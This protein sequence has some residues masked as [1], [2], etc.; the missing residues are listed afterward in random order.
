MDP[1]LEVSPGTRL[2]APSGRIWTIRSVTPTPTRIVIVSRSDEGDRGMVVDGT[3]LLRMVSVAGIEHREARPAPIAAREAA[4]MSEATANRLTARERD[5][6]AL[7]ALGR[8]NAAIAARLV[9]SQGAVEKHVA[10]IFV[11]L[12]LPAS[13]R[14]NRRVLAV[15]QYLQAPLGSGTSDRG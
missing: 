7:M 12:Q 1:T 8:S 15:L 3:A 14:D 9:I 5:V 2:I 4:P 10:N 13:S 11:K 6:L